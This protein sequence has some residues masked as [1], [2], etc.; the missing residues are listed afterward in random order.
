MSD[1]FNLFSVV[2]DSTKEEALNPSA[3]LIGQ[4]FRGLA[5]FVLDPLVK[6]NIVKDI[7]MEKFA[8]KTRNK[9]DKI[10]SENRDDTKLGLTYKAVED[11]VYQLNSEQMQEMFANLITSTVDNRKNDEI[12]P[13]FSS[14]LKDL[15]PIDAELFQFIYEEPAT[16]IGSIRL[17]KQNTSEGVTVLENVI[18]TSDGEINQQSSLETLQRFGLINI[19]QEKNLIAQK[20]VDLYNRFEESETFENYKKELP[21]ETSTITLD[22]AKLLKGNIKLTKLG[23]L[24]GSVVISE[25]V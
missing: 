11:S 2:P 5:H 1:K 9:T 21:Y 17:E 12:K 19:E 8:N 24:F 18:I 20:F 3:N 14:I 7:E 13:S 6:Y 16:V 15:A 23:K 10:P 4:A 25:E 22:S